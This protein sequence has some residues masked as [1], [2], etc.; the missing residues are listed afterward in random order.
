MPPLHT[1]LLTLTLACLQPATAQVYRGMLKADCIV[2]L[3]GADQGSTKVTV[4]PGTAAAYVVFPVTPR[5]V[6]DLPLE[7]TYLLTFEH[8]GTTTKQL[9]VDA[10]VPVEQRTLPFDFPLKVVLEHHDGPFAYAGPVGFIH[11][12]HPITDFGYTTDLRVKVNVHFA[13]RMAALES[14]GTDPRSAIVGYTA[15]TSAVSTRMPERNAGPDLN[16]AWSSTAPTVA[17]TAPLVQR[18]ALVPKATPPP[19]AKPL[20]MV[21]ITTATTPADDMPTMAPPAPAGTLLVTVKTLPAVLVVLP[22]T[23]MV[24][25]RVIIVESRRVTTIVR[26]SGQPGPNAEYRRVAD[27]TGAVYFFLDGHSITE[28]NY[29]SGI[30]PEGNPSTATQESGRPK[31]FF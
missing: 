6:L 22:A 9:Y 28:R 16:T 12:Q 25:E 31:V 29:V 20:P 7:E 18:L 23:T 21:M 10:T 17:L 19:D 26:Y 27:H 4:M 5:F 1:L 30:A 24:R 14:T 13:E 2:Q 15:S 3:K 8:P 11:Y